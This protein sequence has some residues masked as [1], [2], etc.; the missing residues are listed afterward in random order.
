MKKKRKTTGN[1]RHTL[2]SLMKKPQIIL[3]IHLPAFHPMGCFSNQV[4]SYENLLLP[5]DNSLTN[6]LNSYSISHPPKRKRRKRKPN[7][8]K[9]DSMCKESNCLQFCYFSAL[10]ELLQVAHKHNLIWH[11]LTGQFILFLW[12]SSFFF[13]TFSYT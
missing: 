3:L 13:P 11:C 12:I 6:S 9:S 8:E 5:V 2:D 7:P 1:F 10:R 4:T